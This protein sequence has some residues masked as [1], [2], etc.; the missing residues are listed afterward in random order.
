M[1]TNN[2]HPRWITQIL[3]AYS[4]GV[5]HAFLVHFNVND[6]A[7]PETPINTVQYLTKLTANREIVAI[8]SRDRGIEFGTPEQKQAALDVL[9]MGANNAPVD[10]ILAALGSVGGS[11][12]QGELPSDPAQAL[13]LLDT[14]PLS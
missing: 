14:L 2:N 11:Q 5:A 1:T 10:P 6:Y 12:S 4:S 3:E 8:Y 13:P 9:G 7:T